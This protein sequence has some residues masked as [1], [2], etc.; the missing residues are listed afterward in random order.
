MKNKLKNEV[1]IQEECYY[2]NNMREIKEE[3]CKVSE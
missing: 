3:N 2:N 1:K